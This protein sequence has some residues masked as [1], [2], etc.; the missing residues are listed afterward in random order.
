MLLLIYSSTM[1]CLN[2]WEVSLMVGGRAGGQDFR[3]PNCTV[4]VIIDDYFFRS[5]NLQLI[6]YSILIL[7]RGHTFIQ[8]LPMICFTVTVSA[9]FHLLRACLRHFKYGFFS[10]V[11][12]VLGFLQLF[13]G[14]SL[15]HQGYQ[16][17]GLGF[18]NQGQFSH[19]QLIQF[20]QL[21]IQLI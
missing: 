14:S 20:S 18:Q 21:V 19:S 12:F 13:L 3:H 10:R 7:L 8:L 2:F 11:S 5:F 15:V 4:T 6:I 17:Q 16:F 1:G 9:S